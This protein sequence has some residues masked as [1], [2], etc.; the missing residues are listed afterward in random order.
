MEKGEFSID[1]DRISFFS[2]QNPEMPADF[3]DFIFIGI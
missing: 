1:Q 3:V 2:Y